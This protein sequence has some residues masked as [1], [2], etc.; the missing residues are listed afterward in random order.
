MLTDSCDLVRKRS[1]KPI[2][3]NS[4]SVLYMQ[5]IASITGGAKPLAGLSFEGELGE[6]K[7]KREKQIFK[8]KQQNHS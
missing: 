2:W 4:N 8:I 7:K 3:W 5:R 6:P 1:Y